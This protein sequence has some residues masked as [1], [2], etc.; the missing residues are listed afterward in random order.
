VG[1]MKIRIEQKNGVLTETQRSRAE[2]RLAW[3]LGRFSDR[4]GRVTLRIAL[5]DDRAGSTCIRCRIDV[6]LNPRRLSVE[7]TDV[8][9]LAALERAAD[10]VSRTVARAL[11]RENDLNEVVA[12]R[13]ARSRAPGPNR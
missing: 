13:G 10:R 5:A 11:E 3:S 6:G 9:P 4:I 12:G 7:E 1:K 8:D 2:R